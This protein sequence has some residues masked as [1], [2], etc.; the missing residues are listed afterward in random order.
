MVIIC[1]YNQF[2]YIMQTLQIDY[3]KILF[4]ITNRVHNVSNSHITYFIIL[5][6]ILLFREAYDIRHSRDMV[7]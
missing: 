5:L 1:R 2:I 7:T 6:M 3:L 4:K